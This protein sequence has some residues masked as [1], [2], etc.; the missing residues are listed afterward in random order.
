MSLNRTAKGRKPQYFKDPATDGLLNI[1][2]KLIAELSVTRDRLDAT[3]RLLEQL[4]IGFSRSDLDRY[5]ESDAAGRERHFQR[6][7]LIARVLQVLVDE[8]NEAEKPDSF[9]TLDDLVKELSQTD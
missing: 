4:N 6:R 3:E 2:V 7:D 8:V 9:S 1:V 5:E